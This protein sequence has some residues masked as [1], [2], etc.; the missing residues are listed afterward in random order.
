MT[1]T[2]INT[3][4]CHS[5]RDRYWIPDIE[6][7]FNAIVRPHKLPAIK[8]CFYSRDAAINNERKYQNAKQNQLETLL[9]P[10]MIQSPYDFH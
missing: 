6:Y 10:G 7:M 2:E 1:T 8:A 4:R 9:Q 5:K 3:F